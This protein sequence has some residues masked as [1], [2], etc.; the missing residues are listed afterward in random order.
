V[1][2]DGKDTG[3]QMPDMSHVGEP[4]ELTRQGFD[5]PAHDHSL[6]RVDCHGC[7]ARPTAC[8]DCVVTY[9]LGS[10]PQ[11]VELDSDQ[12]VALENLA[13]AGLVP[14]LKYQ[15]EPEFGHGT[16]REDQPAQ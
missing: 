8:G 16:G 1:I 7:T 9:L 13:H 14:A 12:Q 10:A 6:V 11:G 3:F 4:I 5:E 2:T 15:I